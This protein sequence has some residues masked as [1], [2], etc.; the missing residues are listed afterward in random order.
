MK[1]S[2]LNYWPDVTDFELVAQVVASDACL[3]VLP[4]SFF[5]INDGA[6]KNS[7]LDSKK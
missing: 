1:L 2:E 5:C 7:P 6:Y 3:F 4:E